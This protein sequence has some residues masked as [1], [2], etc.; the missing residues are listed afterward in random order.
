MSA[1]IFAH[2]LEFVNGNVNAVY[3]AVKPVGAL[4]ALRSPQNATQLAAS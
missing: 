3:I 1:L 2:P 4:S